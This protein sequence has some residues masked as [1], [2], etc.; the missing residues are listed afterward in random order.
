[1]TIAAST[2]DDVVTLV[3]ALVWPLAVLLILLALRPYL[4]DLVKGLARRVTKVSWASASL[5]F[6]VATEV[7]PEIWGSLQGLRDPTASLRASDSGQMLFQLIRV[8]ERSDSA[9][10]DLGI[11]NRWLTSRL[12]IFSVILSELLGVRCMVFLQTRD[13]VPR[14]FVGLAKP[15]DVRTA[16][17]RRYDWFERALVSSQLNF[18]VATT[19]ATDRMGELKKF[20]ASPAGKPDQLWLSSLEPT[21]RPIFAEALQV[22]LRSAQVAENVAT[23]YLNSPLI[24]R[25]VD[26]S[27]AEQKDWVRLEPDSAEGNVRE[28]HAHWIKDADQL[29]RILGEALSF[30]SLVEDPGASAKDLEKRA[31]L[32]DDG[33]FVAIVDSDG[34]F[35]RLL[36]RRT[37]VERVGRQMAETD[38]GK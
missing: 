35:K 9:T 22:D 32:A 14:R 6:A 1:M 7:R 2:F 15:D 21:L 13:G 10:F 36:N 8:G 37:V 28:E 34:R 3:Q 18:Y 12:Y 11:G 38:A 19:E 26:A 20:L 31:V 24:S 30:P 4:P 23:T 16:L 5:E 25:H 33:E 17:G 27:A 29:N